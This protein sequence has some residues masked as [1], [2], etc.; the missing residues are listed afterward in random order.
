MT[1]THIITFRNFNFFKLLS[2]LRKEEAKQYIIQINNLKQI[3]K[4]DQQNLK[5][6]NGVN[7]DDQTC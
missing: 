3:N 5:N 7:L 2:K 6:K 4:K 1:P